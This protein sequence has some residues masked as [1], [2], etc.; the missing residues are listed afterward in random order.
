MADSATG[1]S[2]S[3]TE[4]AEYLSRT[5]DEDVFDVMKSN[6]ISRSVFLKLS[7]RQIECMIPA[8]V[9]DVVELMALQDEVKTTESDV[10]AM[11]YIKYY[12]TTKIFS[13]SAILFTYS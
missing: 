10:C 6:I 12:T 4:F 9:G 13:V 2:M 1:L 8:A 7:E 11:N 3:V 5:F